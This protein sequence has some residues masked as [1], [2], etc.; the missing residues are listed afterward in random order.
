MTDVHTKSLAGVRLAALDLPGSIRGRGRL[1][2]A[3]GVRLGG[4]DRPLGRLRSRLYLAIAGV[5]LGTFDCRPLNRIRRRG[6]SRV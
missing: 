6:R 1:Y 3:K 4:I 5:R 2:L